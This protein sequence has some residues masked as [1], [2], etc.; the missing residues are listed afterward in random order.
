MT[1]SRI[2]FRVKQI[3]EARGLTVG[4]AAD[5]CGCSYPAMRGLV[6]GSSTRLDIE[7][8]RRICDGFDVG[9]EDVLVRVAP[10]PTAP[11]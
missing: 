2:E 11:A 3:L 7:T 5:L 10:P 9:V 1:E 8:L 6:A 4:Q